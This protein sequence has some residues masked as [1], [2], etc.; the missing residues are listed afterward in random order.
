MGRKILICGLNGT[1]KSTIGKALAKKLGFRF[2]DVEELYFPNTDTDYKYSCSRTKEEVTE[3]LADLFH[4]CENLVFSAVKGDFGG[5]EFDC[6][7]LLTA[8]K[9]VR[10][11]R[12]KNRSFEKFGDRILPGGDLHQRESSF[13]SFVQ[14]RPENLVEEWAEHLN[15]P[16]IRVNAE[17]GVEET[18]SFLAEQ[19]CGQSV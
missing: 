5:I 19:I 16:V 11:Q 13:F 15:C 3:L 14:A 4:T 2:V 10:M 17:K 8:P 1:G 7:I 18:V 9:E 12:V 6:C